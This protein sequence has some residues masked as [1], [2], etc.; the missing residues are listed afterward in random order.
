M[1][2]VFNYFDVLSV[3]QQFDLDY[4]MLEK[5]YLD[6]QQKHHPDLVQDAEGKL[7][8]TRYSAILNDAYNSLKN[9][10]LR[11][12]YLLSLQGM[13]LGDNPD[14]VKPT[15]DILMESMSLREQLSETSDKI[16]LDA[17]MQQAKAMQAESLHVIKHHYA[18]GFIELLAQEV[19]RLRYII[20][21]ASEIDLKI[22]NA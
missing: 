16:K 20:K 6:L 7:L 4:Q 22:Q 5:N 1:T 15:T 18:D 2:N 9:P 12:E 3:K 14:A 19:I 17:L 8:A 21:W 10:L 11:A 13:I